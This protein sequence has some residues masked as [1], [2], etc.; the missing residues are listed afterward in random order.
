M[1]NRPTQCV[2]I[3][4]LAFALCSCGGSARVKPDAPATRVNNEAPSVT[5]APAA[6]DPKILAAQAQTKKSPEREALLL[7]AAEIY[8]S[9]NK[10]RSTAGKTF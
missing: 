7:Q 8:S 1:L 3:S 6:L 4:L 9:Q 5:N 2:L 10:L